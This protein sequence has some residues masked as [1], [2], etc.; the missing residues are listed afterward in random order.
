MSIRVLLLGGHGKVSLLI[1]PLLL[2]RS[3]H[4]TSVIRDPS[5]ADDILSKG[6][7]Q[8][9]T[10]EVLTSSLEDVKSPQQ[11]QTVLN[12]S[13]PDYVIWSAGISTLLF[14]L[15]GKAANGILLG[16]GGKGGASRT[17]AI[18][19][20]ACSHFIRASLSTPT[21]SKFLL[22]SYLGS[23]AKPPSWWTSSEWSACV[24]T[25]TSSLSN[26][27][28]AKL[29]ADECLTA[30][31]RTQPKERGFQ[32]IVLRP[33]QLTDEEATGRV[34][35]GKTRAEGKVSRG[36][37][38]DVGVRLLDGT[39]GGWL[40]LLEG[41]ERVQEAVERVEREEVDCVEGEDIEDMISRYVKS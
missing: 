6:R 12:E 7:G 10:L 18:D 5:Q 40:D 15:T 37:V 33:G 28:V 8:P 13:K 21:V 4:V 27:Y 16:A 14:S 9:G 35:L 26:Y 24:E 23:R 29:A 30:L 2:S 34:S 17:Y 31:A 25:N 19:R 39:K 22:I 1:T 11:A 20:D 36:D 38:A 3:W 32:A 41:E